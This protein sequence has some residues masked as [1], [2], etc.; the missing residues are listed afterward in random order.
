[1]DSFGINVG[2]GY[3]KLVVINEEGQE[4]VAVALPSLVAEAAPA[5]V[6]TVAA[7][8][9]VQIG[10]TDYWVGDDALLA[11][12]QFTDLSVA[13]LS[14]QRLIP[15]LVTRAWQL[16]HLNGS[17]TGVGVS[18]LP[19][20]YAQDRDKAAALA[21]R[22]RETL[23]ETFEPGQLTIIAEPLGLLYAALLDEHGQVSGDA[24]L[25]EGRVGVID[26]GYLSVDVAEVLTLRPVADAVTGWDGGTSRP[27]AAIQAR[28]VET[29][30]R[31]VS[32]YEADTAVR[33][34]GLRVRGQHIALNDLLGTG[35]DAPLIRSGDLIGSRLA[36]RWGSG[37][38]LDA[39][40]MGGG[41]AEMPH[42]TAAI[43]ARFPHAQVVA[44][45]QMAIARGYA[46]YARHRLQTMQYSAAAVGA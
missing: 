13:R 35:W 32:L 21:S 24:A 45:P 14:D 43:Q 8:E 4:T 6:G 38:H 22:L 11:P 29:L 46:R 42:L 40:L 18:G 16:G 7:A 23:P 31:D 41:G 34:G 37:T 3:T 12:Q 30:Q 9:T 27:L 5:L 17:S 1:M 33:A 20:A 44:A 19:A 28:L 2:H 36:E 15:A 25:A 26:V 39:I 10:G